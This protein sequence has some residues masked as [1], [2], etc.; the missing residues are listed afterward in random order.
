[1]KKKEILVMI[2]RL[3]RRVVA[4]VSAASAASVTATSRTTMSMAAM[5]MMGSKTAVKAYGGSSKK[6]EDG[7][8]G[9]ASKL[10]PDEYLEIARNW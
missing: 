7:A 9:A 1:M 5:T 6:E 10:H 4:P 3:I 8:Q 2:S